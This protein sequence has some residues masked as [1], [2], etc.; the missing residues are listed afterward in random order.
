MRNPVVWLITDTHFNADFSRIA[1]LPNPTDKPVHRNIRPDNYQDLILKA[2]KRMIA[3]QDVVIHLG[4]V[5]NDRPGE[6]S[7]IMAKIPGRSKILVRG[8]H[9]KKNDT[10]YLN[11]GF[12]FV[13][14]KIVMG[15]A[16]LSHIPVPIPE[17]MGIDW[18]IHGHFHDNP[19][20]HCFDCEP[21]LKEYYGPKHKRYALEYNNYEPVLLED[22]VR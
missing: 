2:C 9:D 5:I 18:N 8:N 16:I 22:W 11:K 20:D 6:L 3:G 21:Y 13:C 15:N 19:L 7:D 17:N 10:W 4:D 14:D 1:K 12:D